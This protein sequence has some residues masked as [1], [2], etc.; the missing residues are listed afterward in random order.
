MRPLTESGGVVGVTLSTC[1]AVVELA[2]L[3]EGLARGGGDRGPA[4]G[5]LGPGLVVRPPRTSARTDE[6]A[7]RLYTDTCW[8]LR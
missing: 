4:R 5:L 6:V 7:P 8:V 3:L 1:A 2:A